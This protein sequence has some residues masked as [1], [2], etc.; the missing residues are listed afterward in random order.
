MKY[1]LVCPVITVGQSRT[2]V[3]AHLLDESHPS[4]VEFSLKSVDLTL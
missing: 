4:G 2:A 1:R 3:V